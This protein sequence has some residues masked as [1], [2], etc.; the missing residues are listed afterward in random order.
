MK[1]DKV[2]RLMYSLN[3]YELLILVN[4]IARE[5]K[6]YDDPMALNDAILYFRDKK[7]HNKWR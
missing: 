3:K 2:I 1:V 4:A 5:L 6:E 7:W